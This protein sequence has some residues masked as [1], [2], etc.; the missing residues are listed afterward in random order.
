MPGVVRD[1]LHADPHFVL[2]G[3]LAIYAFGLRGI[4]GKIS[5][6]LRIDEDNEVLPDILLTLS[7]EFGGGTWTGE[8]D[9]LNGTPE[10]IVEVAGTSDDVESGARRELYHRLGVKEYLRWLVAED[11][12]EWETL[13]DGEYRELPA[14]EAGVILSEVFPGLWLN[15]PGLLAGD[16]GAVMATLGLGLRSP[17]HRKFAG[18]FAG[19]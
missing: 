11:R 2:N 9:I 5:P 16:T 15:G 19:E 7:P 6:T 4:R 13:A 18:R 8:D 1:S 10:L 17:G 14:D 12:I 3:W